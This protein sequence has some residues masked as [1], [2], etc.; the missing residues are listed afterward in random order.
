MALIKLNR[1]TCKDHGLTEE[2][3]DQFFEAWDR[4]LSE[5]PVSETDK[6]REAEL[7]T[8]EQSGENKEPENER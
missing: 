4:F 8:L 2:D 1:E 6:S 5:R 3:I 7:K